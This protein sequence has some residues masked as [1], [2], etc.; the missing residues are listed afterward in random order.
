M[1][2]ACWHTLGQYNTLGAG[3]FNGRSRRLIRR[4]ETCTSACSR[5]LLCL[6]ISFAIVHLHGLLLV[7]HL[8][9]TLT[10]LF[11]CGFCRCVDAL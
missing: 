5:C 2:R 11:V 3:V 7:I 6:P 8:V 4:L 1:L 10:W 9:N